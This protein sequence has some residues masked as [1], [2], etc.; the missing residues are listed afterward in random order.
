[1]Q[2]YFVEAKRMSDGVPTTVEIEFQNYR[3]KTVSAYAHMHDKIELLYCRSGAFKAFLNGVEH[4]FNKGDMLLI[5]SNEIHQI[6][7]DTDSDNSYM[8]L[9]FEPE[10]IYNS[11]Q[12]I[13]EMKYVLPFTLSRSTHPKIFRAEDLAIN[14]IPELMNEINR[15]FTE[16]KYGY[17]LAMRVCICRLFLWILRHWSSEGLDLNIHS[18]ISERMMY[19]LQ[20]VFDYVNNHFSENIAVSDMAK[21]CNMSYSYFSRLFKRI[22]NRSFSEYLNHI[23]ISK[24]EKL[25]TRTNMNITEVAMEVGFSDTGYFIQKFRSLKGIS[26]RKFKKLYEII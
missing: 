16:K 11:T 25:L 13:F 6:L 12:A 26:P 2:N 23:R 10:M 4:Y 24:A 14:E 7:S 15:E 21:M 3:G 20:R 17:E 8:V 22:M 5:N 19:E 18:D 9:K 1:M